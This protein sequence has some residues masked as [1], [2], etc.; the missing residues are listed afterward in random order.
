MLDIPER[1]R[2][3]FLRWIHLLEMAQ[4]VAAE[5]ADEVDTEK[6]PEVLGFIELFDRNMAEMSSKAATC[7]AAAVPSPGPT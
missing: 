1:D 2:A 5:Q 4:Q 3:P 6:T 7:S